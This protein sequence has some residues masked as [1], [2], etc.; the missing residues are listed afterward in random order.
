[1]NMV[2][3]GNAVQADLCSHETPGY[4]ARL[5]LVER[6]KRVGKVCYVSRPRPECAVEC[7]GVGLVNGL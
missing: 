1:M 6:V 7:F 3:I 4:R 2:K 5:S